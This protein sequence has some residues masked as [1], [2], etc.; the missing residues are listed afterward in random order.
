MYCQDKTSQYC[1]FRTGAI[2]AMTQ[3][4]RGGDYCATKIPPKYKS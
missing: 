4:K 3:R 1:P 2:D